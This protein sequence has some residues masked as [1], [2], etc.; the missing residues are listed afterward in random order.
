LQSSGNRAHDH[1][2]HDAR[3]RKSSGVLRDNRSARIKLRCL[4]HEQRKDE[5][6]EG[7]IPSHEHR[8]QLFFRVEQPLDG[9]IA[10][11]CALGDVERRERHRREEIKELPWQ[12]AKNH[13]MI[14]RAGAEGRESDQD[15]FSGGRQQRYVAG[16]DFSH[17]LARAALY[18]RH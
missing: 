17:P 12:N 18:R 15:E 13:A 5:Q 16:A 7:G 1:E 8:P 11:E 2:A 14:E 4:D 6:C 3:R 9:K 10:P